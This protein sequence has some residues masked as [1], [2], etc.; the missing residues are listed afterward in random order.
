IAEHHERQGDYNRDHRPLDA[1]LGKKHRIRP[2]ESGFL[3]RWASLLVAVDSTGPLISTGRPSL[4][5]PSGWR[6]TS[7]PIDR[8]ELTS[9][10]PSRGSCWPSTTSAR[11]SS[12]WL[13]VQTCAR[14]P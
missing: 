6:S 12:P 7:S 4:S 11:F 13:T 3:E 9:N 10:L 2:Y 1:E 5:M 14:S 8:P